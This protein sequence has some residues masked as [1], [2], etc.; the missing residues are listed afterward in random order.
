MIVM[1]PRMVMAAS[2][3]AARGPAPPRTRSRPAGDDA[4]Q[5]GSASWRPGGASRLWLGAARDS[6]GRDLVSRY[7]P[8]AGIVYRKGPYAQAVQEV[9]P[10]QTA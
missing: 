3:L 1:M 5:P 4:A 10:R 9:R 2:F 6:L 8:G 7:G